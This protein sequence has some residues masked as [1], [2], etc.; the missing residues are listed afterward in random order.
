MEKIITKWW[1]LIVFGLLAGLFGYGYQN[2][3]F[4]QDDLDWFIMANRPVLE[5]MSAPIGDHVNYV[6]R[7][8]LSLEWNTFHFNFPPYLV[9]SLAMH[10]CV[11][12][13]LYKLARL[14]SGRED[15]AAM[16]A[17]L[18]S[19]NTN[20]TE[21]LLWISGQTITITTLFVLLAMLS[22]WQKR[23][24]GAFLLLASWTSALSLGL[25]GA[26]LLVYKKLRIKTMF[27]LVVLAT[28]YKLWAMDG[29][30]IEMSLSWLW[31]V[32]LVGVLAM[33]NSV[34][35]RLLIPFDRFELARIG[36]AGWLMVYGLWTMR[37]KLRDIWRDNWSRFLLI[38]IGLYYLIVAVGR[39]QYGVGIMRA[40]RYVYLGLA[41]FLLLTVRVLRDWKMDKWV[42]VV[43]VVVGLQIAGLY[44]RANW[45]IERPQQL[46]TLV[47]EVKRADPSTINGED[48]LPHFVLN[49]ERLGYGDLV[50]LIDD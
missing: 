14:S 12:G 31:Q 6:W 3:Y 13:L 46:K 44:T 24:E 10:A 49:D 9:V 17:I 15:L 29:T 23:G 19:I 42:W 30:K 41:L 43:G 38:Q 40:E 36:I 34:V 8:L 35:G 11:V 45:Y 48:F 16:A 32:G 20:W 21:T 2:M 4:H 33:I 1:P 25:L 39:A 37:G 7:L 47:E 50:R 27:V 22:I 28:I 18:F 26:S 5:L